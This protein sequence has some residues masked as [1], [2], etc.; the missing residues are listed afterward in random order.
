MFLITDPAVVKYISFEMPLE[1]QKQL[2][3]ML[4]QHFTEHTV[5]KLKADSTQIEKDIMAQLVG[6]MDKIKECA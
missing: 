2:I 6:I 3:S 1:L 5:L 4:I